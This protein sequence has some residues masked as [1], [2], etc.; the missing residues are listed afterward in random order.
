MGRS[1]FYGLDDSVILT[2]EQKVALHELSK[3]YRKEFKWECISA[4]FPSMYKYDIPE[5]YDNDF[6]DDQFA[7]DLEAMFERNKYRD[8]NDDDDDD[9]FSFSINGV[10]VD[11][12][13]QDEKETILFGCTL[14]GGNE[15]DAHNVIKF[16]VDASKIIP[17]EEFYL[18]DDGFALY[19]P[20]LI[21][22]GLA[23]PDVKRINYQLDNMINNF[24]L[25]KKGFYDPAKRIKF[26]QLVLEHKEWTDIN[27]FVRPVVITE[28]PEKRPPVDLDLDYDDDNDEISD[29]ALEKFKNELAIEEFLEQSK[30]YDD[31][32]YYPEKIG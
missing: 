19:C 16:M 11:Q 26:F 2:Q 23:S 1:L 4:W 22:N 30:Y 17:D 7:E 12:I 25:Q 27:K 31:I 24:L 32:D 29:E 21:K 3:K 28:R 10:T 6:D 18:D 15:F 5:T 8:E 13:E 14:A 20:V 9:E